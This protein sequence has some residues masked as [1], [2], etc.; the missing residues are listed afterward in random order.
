MK[1]LDPSHITYSVLDSGPTI[2]EYTTVSESLGLDPYPWSGVGSNLTTMVPEL[3]DLIGSIKGKD[4]RTS[5]CV[6][7]IFGWKDYCGD[8]NECNQTGMANKTEPPAKAKR[9]MA[10]A[11]LTL[12]CR[13]LLLYSYYDL[14]ETAGRARAPEAVITQRLADLKALG[15]EV[16]GYEKEF[17]GEIADEKLDV[18]GLPAGAVAGLR[19]AKEGAGGV[20]ASEC[21]LFVVNLQAVEQSAKVMVP[22]PQNI[23]PSKSVKLPC[24]W[25]YL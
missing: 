1:S 25:V 13:G 11:A 8:N 7:Q 6:T 19:C 5:V 15:L 2:G 18:S 17:L 10:F 14:Y 12:G 16:K 4:K 22:T 21:T 24:L 23:A 20:E 9:A 3:Q